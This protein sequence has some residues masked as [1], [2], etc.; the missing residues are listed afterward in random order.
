MRLTSATVASVCLAALAGCGGG[1]SSTSRPPTPT[2]RA[3]LQQAAYDFVTAKT[4]ARNPQIVRMRVA[5]VPLG[6]PGASPYAAFALVQLS[7]PDAGYAV[8]LLGYRKRQLSGWRV[9]ALG[10]MQVGCGLG[11]N[12]FGSHGPAVRRALGLPCA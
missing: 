5:S 1:H 9:L 10:S 2:E 12:V 11:R 4:D 3:A 6:S 8:A 7:D